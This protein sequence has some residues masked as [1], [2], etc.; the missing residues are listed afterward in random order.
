MLYQ[1]ADLIRGKSRNYQVRVHSLRKYF[2]TQITA[3]GVNSDYIEYMTGHVIDTC[4]DVQMK[5]V[6]S[7]EHLHLLRHV[8]Q[9][10]NTSQQARCSQRDNQGMGNEPGRDPVKNAMIQPHRTVV[11][12]LT[13]YE[14]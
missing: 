1:R 11:N 9:T 13:K 7:Q 14:Y 12:H 5:G 4:H 2:K 8:E 3:L 6:V 10:K